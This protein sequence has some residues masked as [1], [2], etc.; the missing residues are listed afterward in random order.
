MVKTKNRK[1]NKTP[2]PVKLF[3]ALL[4]LLISVELIS[5]VMGASLFEKFLRITGIKPST[6]MER[7]E[8][9]PSSVYNDLIYLSYIDSL[10]D[11]AFHVPQRQAD[12][13]NIVRL[14]LETAGVTQNKIIEWGV[15]ESG[16]LNEL[17]INMYD[18]ERIILPREGL[19]L[20]FEVREGV[21]Q[22]GYII[23]GRT[24]RDV[25]SNEI[26]FCAI[27]TSFSKLWPERSKIIYCIYGNGDENP[28]IVH[29][30]LENIPEIVYLGCGVPGDDLKA[31]YQNIIRPE[32]NKRIR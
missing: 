7:Y 32:K 11:K 23:F 20:Y 12:E 9:Q 2:L 18:N 16:S 28:E 1:K 19:P 31:V 4:I 5:R 24:G 3:T 25:E 13:K 8:D 6:R 26:N 21:I 30:F 15:P 14:I 17:F 10:A 22:M 29:C 27:V